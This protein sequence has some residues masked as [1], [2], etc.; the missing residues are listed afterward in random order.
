MANQTLEAWNW[1]LWHIKS[2]NGWSTPILSCYISLCKA[3]LRLCVMSPLCPIWSCPISRGFEDARLGSYLLNNAFSKQKSHHFKHFAST[4]TIWCQCLVLNSHQPCWGLSLSPRSRPKWYFKV[5][6]LCPNTLKR[7]RALIKP[8]E[9]ARHLRKKIQAWI[10]TGWHSHLTIHVPLT[11]LLLAL[12][13][14]VS[15]TRTPPGISNLS[16]WDLSSPRNIWDSFN[17]RQAAFATCHEAFQSE[18]A[19]PSTWALLW[20]RTTAPPCSMGEVCQALQTMAYYGYAM[21]T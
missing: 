2:L 10:G 5:G 6:R 19:S 15:L 1:H 16:R 13:S 7:A 14:F 3:V 11:L 17:C 18:R 20:K 12:I 9:K 8:L 4:A 21:S